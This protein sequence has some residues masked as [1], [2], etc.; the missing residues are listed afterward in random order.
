MWEHLW[1]TERAL[2]RACLLLAPFLGL[3]GVQEEALRM[4]G[5]ESDLRHCM[6]SL[7]HRSDTAMAR[8]P[9]WL[10]LTATRGAAGANTLGR[11]SMQVLHQSTG[12]FSLDAHLSPQKCCPKLEHTE[13]GQRGE[14]VAATYL[15]ALAWG[16]CLG[17]C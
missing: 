1:S 7:Q 11:L 4:A 2:F 16:S 15:S 13:A 3:E 5:P 14:K 6:S 8:E 12:G 17:C 9:S 10:G